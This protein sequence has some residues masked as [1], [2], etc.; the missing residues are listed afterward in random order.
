MTVRDT[1][2]A[3]ADRIRNDLL[4]V[5]LRDVEEGR[6]ETT[7]EVYQQMFPG[8]EELVAEEIRQLRAEAETAM[9]K[10]IV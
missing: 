7:V 2:E 8:F 9:P 10:P 6:E 4:R 1:D 5:Y 3:S